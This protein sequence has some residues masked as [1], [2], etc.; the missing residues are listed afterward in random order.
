MVKINDKKQKKLEKNQKEI[1]RKKMY[2]KM[3]S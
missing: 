3:N 2:Q 1:K